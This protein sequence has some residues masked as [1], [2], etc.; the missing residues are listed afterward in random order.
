MEQL[1]KCIREL[2]GAMK[3]GRRFVSK[4]EGWREDRGIKREGVER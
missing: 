1:W 2:E 3:L 4:G